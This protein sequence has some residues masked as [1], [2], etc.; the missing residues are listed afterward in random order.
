MSDQEAMMFVQSRNDE[1]DEDEKGL[2]NNKLDDKLDSDRTTASARALIEAQKLGVFETTLAL[3]AATV[4]GEIVAIPFAVQRLGIWLG[5]FVFLAVAF[6][7]H[8]SNM[9]Y[10]QVKDLS[11]GRYES[12][13]E[14]AYALYGRSAIFFV[15]VV[16]Y[17]LSF[18]GIVLYFI[19]LS[20][21]FESIIVAIVL[22]KDAPLGAAARK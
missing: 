12:V 21:A 18:A 3:V 1:K 19:V 16:Q 9:M 15:C 2:I 13:Y 17:M 10:L 11:G 22:G 14:L 8:I 5:L 4:G 6:L 7:S 20:D